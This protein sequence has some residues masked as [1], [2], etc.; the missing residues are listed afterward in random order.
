MSLWN[1]NILRWHLFLGKCI[2]NADISEK[3]RNILCFRVFRWFRFGLPFILSFLSR[4]FFYEFYFSSSAL[5]SM[6][7]HY[8]LSSISAGEKIAFITIF[9]FMC[10][11]SV[12]CNNMCLYILDVDDKQWFRIYRARVSQK[13]KEITPNF[14]TRIRRDY[15]EFSSSCSWWLKRIKLS[16][17]YIEHLHFSSNLFYSLFSILSTYFF[18]KN[19]GEHLSPLFS[20]SNLCNLFSARISSVC[21]L[22]VQLGTTFYTSTYFR[23]EKNWLPFCLRLISTIKKIWNNIIAHSYRRFKTKLWKL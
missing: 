14:I 22:T 6:S 12:L 19:G 18:S 8:I 20:I 5:K 2:F 11:C 16:V 15:Y 10:L 13:Y 21:W 3:V 17:V 23:T 1:D 7:K 9:L 4:S